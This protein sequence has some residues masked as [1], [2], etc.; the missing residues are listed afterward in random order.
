MFNVERTV[1]KLLSGK[2]EST[3]LTFTNAG[4]FYYVRD[5]NGVEVFGHLFEGGVFLIA[6]YPIF[7]NFATSGREYIVRI[8]SEDG[9]DF[10][11]SNSASTRIPICVRSDRTQAED[12]RIKYQWISNNYEELIKDIRLGMKDSD[13]EFKYRFHSVDNDSYRLVR[14]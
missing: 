10:K 2:Y 9:I 6:G 7:Y 1:N 11:A 12:L 5:K 3:G 4:K 8:K 13:I 14:K